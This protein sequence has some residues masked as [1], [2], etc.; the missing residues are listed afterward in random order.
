M[1]VATAGIPTPTDEQVMWLVKQEGDPE[2]FARLVHRWQQPLQ[3]LCWRMTGDPHQA[4]DLTQT[5]FLKVFA[6]RA[7]WE[8][9]GRFSTFLWRVALNLC[10][11]ELRRVRRRSE[12]PLQALETPEGGGRDLVDGGAA[13]DSAAAQRDQGEQVRRA[14]LALSPIHREVLILRHYEGFKFHEI[15]SLLR[16]PEGTVKSRMAEGLTHLGRRLGH[17]REAGADASVRAAE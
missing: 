6:Q 8:P 14:L 10:H 5:A 17:L 2:V 1:T 4:E 9:G 12:L 15:A 13:P 16:V 11:D 7:A 3:R